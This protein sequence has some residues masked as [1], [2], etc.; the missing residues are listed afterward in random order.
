MPA[1]S[2]MDRARAWEVLHA[3]NAAA[4]D[5]GRLARRRGDAEHSCPYGRRDEPDLHYW[6]TEGFYGREFEP[7]SD[8]TALACALA[9]HREA[10]KRAG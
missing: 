10:L 7:L 1:L 3:A 8:D 5:A 2:K 6:W 9:E 4:H